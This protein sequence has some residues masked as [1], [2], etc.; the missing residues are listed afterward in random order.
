MEHRTAIASGG[1][2]RTDSRHGQTR[3]QAP[4]P[5]SFGAGRQFRDIGAGL[6]GRPAGRPGHIVTIRA[7]FVARVFAAIGIVDR[8][9]N[10]GVDE[11]FQ[12]HSL[13]HSTDHPR[14]YS[15]RNSRLP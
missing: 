15:G 9:K 7:H 11:S 8:Q 13:S 3:A 1:S 4:A 10:T 5:V 6:A 2:R 12:I 14:G